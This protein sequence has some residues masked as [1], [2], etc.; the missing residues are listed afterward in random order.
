MKRAAIVV[1]VLGGL[2][3]LV[4][5]LGSLSLAGRARESFGYRAKGMAMAGEIPAAEEKALRDFGADS[6]AAPPALAAATPEPEPPRDELEIAADGYMTGSKR[7][8]LKA[9]VGGKGMPASEVEGDRGG[10]GQEAPTRSWFPETFLFEPLVVTDQEGRANVPVRVPDRLTRWRV[11]ALAH[12]RAGAQAGALST[13]EGTLPAYVDP[14]VPPFLTAGD[15]VRLPVQLVNTT[16][17]DLDRTL[18]LSAAG[19]NLAAAGGSVRVPAQGTLVQYAEL[20][21]ERPGQVVVKASLG[22]TDA[23]ERTIEVKPAGRPL[24]VSKGGTLAAPREVQLSG[25]AD[26]LPES[27]RVRLLVFPGALALL[28]SEL[29]TALHRAGTA[30]DAYSLLMAGRAPALLRALGDEPDREVLRN[31]ALV[32]GQRAIHH[33]RSPDISS[34]AL[35]AEAA[36]AHP[37]NPVLS[38]LGE[39]LAAMVAGAQ[40]PDGTCQGGNGWTLQRLLVA[41]A[42]C[43]KAVGAGKATEA[44]RQRSTGFNLRASGAF[45]RNAG[46]IDDGYTAAAILASG[47]LKGSLAEELRAK[48]RAAIAAQQDGSKVLQADEGVV[49]ADG[50]VPTQAEATALAVLALEGDAQAPMA[51]LGTSLLA[52]YSPVYG[53]GDGRTNLACMRAVLQLFKEPVPS[54]VRVVLEMDGN[55]VTEGALDPSRLKDVVALEAPAPGSSGMHKWRVRAEPAVPGLGFSLTLTA[56]VPWKQEEPTGGLDLAIAS[57]TELAV[58]RP[59]EISLSATAPAGMALKIRHSLPAGVQPDTPSLELLVSSGSISRFE[60]EDGAVQ[61]EVPARQAG[62]PFTAKYRLVPTLAGKLHASA[63]TITPVGRPDLMRY[64]AP[65]TWVVR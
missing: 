55:P 11:L 13:F 61:L 3:V 41:T 51:D 5:V 24:S 60:T 44:A 31:L 1:V 16:E 50:S 25:P 2:V 8:L 27:E 47:A 49:R 33:S 37:D 29:S 32:S 64:V 15:E 21:V 59:A 22:D 6:P 7:M 14:V 56:Y 28:R 4:L 53:W 18:K 58:G 30:D 39:R 43:A 19:A 12:S 57:P 34:A 23:V 52:G 65:A 48:V 38:R 62:Q 35:L 45:E 46:R 26:P 42:D 40:L 17:T 20:K 63:S 9:K 10:E 54:N 36:L